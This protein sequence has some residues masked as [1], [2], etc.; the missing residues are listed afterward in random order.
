MTLTWAKFKDDLQR[1][2]H[3][4]RRGAVVL[5]DPAPNTGANANANSNNTSPGPGN[6]SN[7]TTEPFPPFD[8]TILS[9]HTTQPA[10]STSH[11]Y[12][13]Q[14]DG[15]NDSNS[16]PSNAPNTT[17][18]EEALD[19][20]HA[21][22][23][24]EN[25]D[26]RIWVT[27]IPG[28]SKK[29]SKREQ[30]K[31]GTPKLGMSI[32]DGDTLKEI[33]Q[34]LGE[35]VLDHTR[36]LVLPRPKIY[37]DIPSDEEG[38]MT[39]RQQKQHVKNKTMYVVQ[40]ETETWFERR[41]R[42]REA[43][44]QAL[45]E[46]RQDEEAEAEEERRAL[47]AAMQSGE[48]SSST[49]LQRPS[50]VNPTTNNNLAIPMPND[51][52][53]SGRSRAN[54]ALPTP[55]EMYPGRPL[56]NAPPPGT[57]KRVVDGP[58]M[59]PENERWRPRTEAGPS[60]T[61]SS[62]NENAQR[63][64]PRSTTPE[65]SPERPHNTWGSGNGTLLP[66]RSSSDVHRHLDTEGHSEGHPRTP[67][68]IVNN[69]GP[70]N[71][72][73]N[74]G[75]L[76]GRR[77]TAGERSGQ[78]VA[79]ADNGNPLNPDTANNESPDYFGTNTSTWGSWGRNQGYKVVYNGESSAQGAATAGNG[80]SLSPPQPGERTPDS[81]R[82][83]TTLQNPEEVAAAGEAQAV[84]VG[85][86][87]NYGRAQVAPESEALRNQWDGA[88]DEQHPSEPALQ[89]SPQPPAQ[90][91]AQLPPQPPAQATAQL[92][93][94]PPS[95][96]TSRQEWKWH[97]KGVS[98][99]S[100][101]PPLTIRTRL[102]EF[103][104]QQCRKSAI[105]RLTNDTET[106]AEGTPKEDIKV[107][108]LGETEVVV[109][110]ARQT[111]GETLPK[112]YLSAEEY[113]LYER[114][115]GPPL[116]ETKAED[117]EYLP[118]AEEEDDEPGRNNVLLRELPDGQFEEV[119]FDPDLGFE[120]REGEEL[121]PEPWEG[122]GE[123]EGVVREDEDGYNAHLESLQQSE[124]LEVAEEGDRVQAQGQNQREI[125]AIARL[126]KDMDAAFARP[127]EE[128]QEEDIEEEY[129]EEEEIEEEV[130][131][132]MPDAYLDSD[133]VRTH[134]HTMTGR[135]GTFPS[136]LTL[137]QEHFVE[138]ISELLDR[139]K[140][141][142]LSDAAENAFGGL[143]LPYSSATPAS[144]S[145]LPQ[146]HIGL[147]AF[148]HRMTEVEADAYLAA[149]MPG[150]YASAMSTLVEVRKRL[151]TNWLRKLMFRGG[152]QGPRVLDAGAGGAGAI[153]WKEI[154]QAEWDAMKE[155]GLARGEEPP[156][157]K[158]T[159]LTG[160]NSL[161][162]RVSRF[163]ENTTFL[164]R[165]PDYIHASSS[166]APVEGSAQPRK[167][168]DVIIAP[169]TLFPLKEEYRRK[170]MVQNLWSLLDP[171]GGVLILIEKG[172][173]RGFEAI[174]GARSLLL[175]HHISSPGDTT[176]ENEIESPASEHTRFADKEEGMIIAP[177]TNHTKCPMYLTPG[178]SVGRKDYCHFG[179]RF[180]RPGYLQRVLGASIRN[181]EDVKFSY[182]AVRRGVDGRKGAQPTLQGD[183]A[184]DQ[185]FEGYEEYDLPDPQPGEE[186]SD[187]KFDPLSLPRTILSPLKRR[188]HVTLD[189]CTPSGKLERWTVPK[190]FSRTAYRD[191]RKSKWGDLWALGAKT[192]VLRQP[193]MGRPGEEG[194]RG[195]KMK[196][197]RDGR[198]GKGGKK[199]KKQKFNVIMG[200]N[201]FEGI[202][203]D[204]SQSKYLKPKKRTKGGRIYKEPKPIGEDDL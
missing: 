13:R 88:Y 91:T 115:Y 8:A 178:L 62:G 103:N 100:I 66:Q 37:S 93:P 166:K 60:G 44:R 18:H 131:E 52:N 16:G 149:V 134:P 98:V 27:C 70:I 159:V 137:P 202:E 29:P 83:M 78:G 81:L 45:E 112:D 179:Q 169:H 181:H 133:T 50:T 14:W 161:R 174:A 64:T 102:H 160:A 148:Q 111:F 54:S 42:K 165:L 87:T 127:A 71:Y 197:V 145:N 139:V 129:E 33:I 19:P 11:A 48:P 57:Q 116:R 12:I 204:I 172:I 195:G 186:I 184:T 176:T 123:E 180:I 89:Q 188:G 190:S 92:P 82:N 26:D 17:T 136:T 157:G 118:E 199:V 61:A 96:Q 143:G 158:T 108:T 203:H 80:N 21:N 40:P 49:A 67:T 3:R 152:G 23:R 126:Q 90:A 201:G 196:G 63:P 59:K 187:I 84:P 31:N 79:T 56:W 106:I 94:Q 110:Q 41:E 200:K 2:W 117:L 164:P 4:E 124:A 99:M 5:T 7:S 107:R 182:V 35:D 101:T 86:T 77:L 39:T 58:V 24:I 9:D 75:P 28:R 151:G 30:V 1:I 189:L 163:L 113:I 32:K 128:E 15:N 122:E 68:I 97:T 74:T 43:K 69:G 121:L 140:M 168:Y 38:N 55:D 141:K 156:E 194:G 125:D 132:D 183:A 147:D 114:L 155:E 72:S 177:C 173:P 6:N 193:R 65:G 146:K 154:V 198:M 162:H 135:S 105:R 46:K 138:P 142:H 104:A 76:S 36:H 73:P 47:A 191:A 167:V 130:E 192:R 85:Q 53:A 153:A 34:I 20:S 95:Q 119:E 25:D 144:K 185:S 150:T 109:R 22:A 10:L 175:D 171:K 120:V 51:E 170:N